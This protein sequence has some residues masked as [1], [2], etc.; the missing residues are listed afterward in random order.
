MIKRDFYLNKLISKKENGKVKVITGLRRVGKSYLL[1]EIYKKYLLSQNIE[2]S[3][4]LTFSLEGL[5]KRYLRDPIKLYEE[6]KKFII[7]K[8]EMY[9]LFIDEIQFVGEIQ[10]P[11]VNFKDT[12]TFVDTILELMHIK[13]LDIYITGSNSKMLSTDILSQFS[14]RSDQIRVN[15]LSFRELYNHFG[16]TPNLLRDYITYGG[17]PE[18]YTKYLDY[19]SR[20]EYLSN[21]FKETYIKDILLRYNIRTDKEN[22]ER[23]LDFVSSSVGSLVNYTRIAD[24]LQSEYQ[25]KIS[26][27]SIKDYLDYFEDSFILSQTK[28][29]D[30]KGD[31]Y[32]K[33]PY[34]YYFN[35]IGLRN[36][37]L[38]FVHED[39]GHI[40][41]NV[42]YNDL[43]SKGYSID[44]G[45]VSKEEKINDKVTKK[46]YEIDFIARKI[47]KR[48][49]IQAALSINDNNVRLREKRPFSFINGG[50]PRILVIGDN[51]IARYDKD[52]I[53][54]ISLKDFL[55][56]EDLEGITKS[57]V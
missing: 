26:R 31:K 28:R 8:D 27:D 25:I 19:T 1:F 36:S 14:G 34:K 16:D 20:A 6:I 35:D 46:Q 56:N 4:I 57:G 18:I 49:Y 7:D 11:D 39:R 51:D 12:I 23:L 33:T 3:K 42:I 5:E 30:I 54:Q 55:L 38:D 21:L 50:F 44:I 10:N 24:K 43:I 37:R 13:N 17:L 2:S 29:Y 9:Y 40:I 48:Y 47:N 53:Y 45:V 15:P 41:E 22:L 32:L 52:G